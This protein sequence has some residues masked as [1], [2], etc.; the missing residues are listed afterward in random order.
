MQNVI[1]FSANQAVIL[2]L[3]I[4]YKHENVVGK[5]TLQ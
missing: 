2:F 4:N 3:Q 1:R 5:S